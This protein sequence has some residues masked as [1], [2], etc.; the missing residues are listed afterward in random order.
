VGGK[1]N[2]KERRGEGLYLVK[3][4]ANDDLHD[5]RWDVILKFL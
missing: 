3:L 5:F 4:I 1:G 2:D